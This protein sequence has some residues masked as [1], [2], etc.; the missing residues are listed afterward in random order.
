MYLVDK[1][2]NSNADLFSQNFILNALS[3][4]QK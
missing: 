1:N 2:V 3:R 4:Q